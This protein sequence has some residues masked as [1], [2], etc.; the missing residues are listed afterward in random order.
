MSGKETHEARLERE[1][2]WIE[3]RKPVPMIITN[4]KNGF[5][6]RFCIAMIGYSIPKNQ[7]PGFH[8]TFEETLAHIKQ[9]HL[10]CS[11]QEEKS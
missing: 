2:P 1:Y 7:L 9:Q 11:D 10:S 6:C 8:E 4:L 3:W 5:G